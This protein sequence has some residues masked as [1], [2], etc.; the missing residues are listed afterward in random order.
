MTTQ[1]PTFAQPATE[2]DAE[3][4]PPDRT[5]AQSERD[6][7]LNRICEQW[8]TWSSTRRLYG[9]PSMAPGVLARLVKASPTRPFSEHP[10]A[11]CSPIMPCLHIAIDGQPKT[12]DR[13]VFEL[14]YKHRVRSIK[15]HAAVLGISR[16]HWYRL[17][18]D[19]RSRVV[20]QAEAILR[21][22]N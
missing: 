11:A 18:S 19:F 10:D 1:P 2:N 8:A 14:H 4:F 12:V 5:P 3:N 22:Q 17:L 6:D 20:L 15:T 7:R 13:I 21:G 16:A 9:S